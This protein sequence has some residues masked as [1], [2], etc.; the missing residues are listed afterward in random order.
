MSTSTSTSAAP[1]APSA[2]SEAL[3]ALTTTGAASGAEHTVQLGFL[4]EG[5]QL[6]VVAPADGDSPHPAWYDDLLAHPMVQVELDGESF[7]AIAVPVEGARR[8]A[9]L[10][11]AAGRAPGHAGQAPPVVVLERAAPPEGAPAQVANL[12]EKLLE[13]H[14]WLRAQLRH[15]SAETDA[16][17][18]AQAAR[19]GAGDPPP[20]G[21]G[22]QIRQH[23]LA[24][25]QSL[26]F[27]HTSED[28]HLFPT[29]AGH[30]PHLREA[31]DRLS[32]EHRTVSRIQNELAALLADI[33]TADPRRF[34]VELDRMTRELTAHLDYEEEMLLP[35][36][37]EI[38]WPPVP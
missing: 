22:F 19:T 14:A 38:P 6:A 18:A 20:P 35:P 28:A 2:S 8:D 9:L 21:L 30:H 7:E 12:A 33:R 32:A 23:C 27:H 31:F 15:I 37:A 1:S 34:R 4:R 5:D 25:C 24:F 11:R 26:E 13:V 29:M 36:L 10:Q 3:L 16:H 17:F